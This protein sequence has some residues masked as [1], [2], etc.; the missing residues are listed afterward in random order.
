MQQTQRV[1]QESEPAADAAGW[2]HLP[3]RL[4]PSQQRALLLQVR[5]A[6]A[7]A[8]LFRPSMPRTGKAFSVLMTN[9][10]PLGW[11]SDRDDGY[12][13]QSTHPE[14][15]R[16]WPLIPDLLGAIWNEVAGYRAPPEACLV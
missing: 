1:C 16:A 2:R 12:R 11:V 10:G 7:A 4:S 9:C 8:P 14:T 13:Y 15:G 6:I 3:G 5:S